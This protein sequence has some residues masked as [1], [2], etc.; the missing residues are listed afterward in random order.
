M[1]L[2]STSLIRWIGLELGITHSFLEISTDFMLDVI[3]LQSLPEFSKY[4]PA[5]FRFTMDT[6]LPETRLEGRNT[7]FRIPAG[8]MEPE[9]ILGVTRVISDVVYGTR[10][11]FLYGHDINVFDRQ[12]RADIA[13]VASLPTTFKYIQPNIIEVYPHNL[14][15]RKFL[16][17]LKVMHNENFFTI[18]KNL[19]TEFLKLALIDVKRSLYNIR[20][21]FPSISTAFGNL[22]FDMD[23]VQG[24]EDKRNELLEIWSKE[25]YKSATRK[26][27]WIG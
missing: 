19:E 12:I 18:P 9:K 26:R 25:F 10:E 6:S 24:M 14:F 17:E 16:V 5:I 27:I 7:A 23:S 22:E 21:N 15:L 4:Y 1:Y 13:S 20:K 8:I 2:T 11:G 3:R